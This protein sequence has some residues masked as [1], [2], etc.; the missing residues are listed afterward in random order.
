MPNVSFTNY[1]AEDKSD[2]KNRRQVRYTGPAN[3]VAGGDPFL[4]SDVKLGQIHVVGAGGVMAW[5]G[6]AVRLVVWDP[7]NQKLVW[8]VP[9][10]GSEVAGGQ[11]LSGFSVDLEIIGL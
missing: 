11:D 6:S 1:R 5:S 10:T 2:L 7:T 8:Y 4:P 9:N 3:Y